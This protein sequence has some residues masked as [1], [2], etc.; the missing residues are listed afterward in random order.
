M[1]RD[2]LI[3]LVDYYGNCD[4]NGK[5]VGHSRKVLE[6][7]CSLVKGEYEVDAVLPKC[8]ACETN[9]TLFH[10]ISLLPFQIMEEGSRGIVKRIIDKVKL[11][12]N[13][14]QALKKSKGDIIWFYRTDFFLFFYFCLFK[15]PQK[16]KIFCLV[17]QQKFAEG[18]LGR[19]LNAIYQ[20]GLT[21]FDGVIY[22]QRNMPPKHDNTFYMPDYYYDQNKYGK[23][24]NIKK[25]YLAVCLGTMSS[26]K[27]LEELVEA[28]NKNEIPLEIRGKFFTRGRINKLMKA[29][30]SNVYIEDRILTEDEYYLGLAE[31]QFIILPYDMKQYSGRTSGVLIEALFMHTVPVAPRALLDEN[32]IVGI[33]YETLSELANGDILREQYREKH[34]LLIEQC[35]KY[36]KKE[37][38]SSGILDFL[39]AP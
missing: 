2:K 9:R 19:I 13:I 34:E 21:K 18:S 20:R 5:A 36:P 32:G 28:F 39:N 27:K 11:F 15:R 33:G 23:F 31:A 1:N 17:Y 29:A 24:L 10:E 37:E 30:R 14:Y 3:T 7:Y 38:I 8:I 26:Y 35:Q 4:A 12:V 22:S 25:K 16:Q 6:E